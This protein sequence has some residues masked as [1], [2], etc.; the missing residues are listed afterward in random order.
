MTP[1]LRPQACA[2]AALA[3]AI[4]GPEGAGAGPWREVGVAT[5]GESF[6][7]AG[8]E[9]AAGQGAVVVAVAGESSPTIIHA[10]IAG[11]ATRELGP[12]GFLFT[13][14]GGP[15]E[16][17]LGL[18]PGQIRAAAR[19]RVRIVLPGR[20]LA[21]RWTPAGL[22]SLERGVLQ[23]AARALRDRIESLDRRAATG[24]DAAGLAATRATL[25]QELDLVE[26]RLRRLDTD[27]VAPPPGR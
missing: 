18:G 3:F 27:P 4:A 23:A 6:S 1:R 17:R 15:L 19:V 5:V 12:A 9:L 2:I 24:G 7:A 10:R 13:P 25:R 21:D 11:G 22:I 16:L 20:D 8:L 14:V 26:A